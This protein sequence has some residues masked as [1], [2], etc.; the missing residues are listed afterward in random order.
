MKLGIWSV[1]LWFGVVAI[2]QGQQIE[3]SGLLTVNGATSSESFAYTVQ[4]ATPERERLLRTQIQV[5]QP[6]VL[7]HRIIFVPHWQYIYSTKMYH[8]H[9]PT[10]MTSKMFTHLPSRS[11]FV[12]EDR[13]LGEDWLGH[14]M[15]HELGHLSTNS[16]REEDAE[17]AAREYRMRLKDARKGDPHSGSS[18][19]R[20]EG[21]STLG[22]DA[23]RARK[24]VCSSN[25]SPAVALRG[26]VR[27]AKEQ[28]GTP[29]SAIRTHH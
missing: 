6:T 2:G 4:G 13:Y 29:E 17:R 8:L 25:R 19:E 7:P 12:D 9:V 20:L 22:D 18:N 14:W 24:Q 11:I 28:N 15:A 21:A 16:A 23:S 5:M 3:G 27:N 10:G 26:F 1:V